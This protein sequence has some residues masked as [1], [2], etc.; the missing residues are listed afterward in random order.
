MKNNIILFL[1]ILSY[2]KPLFY[3]IKK[4]RNKVSLS[5]IICNLECRNYIKTYLTLLSFF[6]I[7]YELNRNNLYSLL[8]MLFFI[9]NS[10]NMINFDENNKN[11]IIYATGLFFS[12]FLFM[13]LHYNK[14]YFLKKLYYIQCIF[15]TIFIYLMLNNLSIIVIESLILINFGIYFSIL[16]F[17]SQ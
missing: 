9:Y 17:Y 4:F 8:I 5:T 7:L 6:I 13:M 2:L 15:Y 11:H 16:H 3:I 14:N 10:I 12:L 1:I